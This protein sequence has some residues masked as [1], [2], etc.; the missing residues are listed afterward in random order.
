MTST[1]TTDHALEFGGIGQERMEWTNRPTYQQVIEFPARRGDNIANLAL[2]GSASA[3]TTFIGHPASNAIDGDPSTKWQGTRTPRAD[4][5]TVDLG[6]AKNVAR[7]VADWAT[8]S[9]EDYVVEV[10]TLGL[11]WTQVASV[12]GGGGRDVLRFA[13][14]IARYVR[15]SGVAATPAYSLYEL[16]IYAR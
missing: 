4:T 8:P 9:V 1:A 6:S 16:G 14:R 15:V 3:S 12:T 10:S 13:P 7:V 2:G 5:F 11:S